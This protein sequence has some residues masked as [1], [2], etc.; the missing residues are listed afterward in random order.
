MVADLDMAKVRASKAM[1]DNAGHYPRP[2]IF[3]LR[4]H[5]K[6]K[7]TAGEHVE[8][9][10]N[11]DGVPEFCCRALQWPV[12]NLPIAAC[13]KYF[14]YGDEDSGDNRPEDESTDAEEL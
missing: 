9:G 10:K 8:W 13:G 1:V 12:A 2:D 7:P 11:A 14:P 4:V 6:L 3:V 5:R